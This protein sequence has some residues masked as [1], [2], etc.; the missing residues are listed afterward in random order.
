L[1]K[2]LKNSN[3][4]KIVS[5][6]PTSHIDAYSELKKNTSFEPR[7]D[8]KGNVA[9]AV[10][11]FYTM[12]PSKAGNISR[13]ADKDTL[14][15]WHTDDPVDT[16]ERIRNDRIE[17]RQGNRN[18]YID[19]PSLVA[20]AWGHGNSSGGNNLGTRDDIKR[21]KSKISVMEESLA[22]LKDELLT[23]ENTLIH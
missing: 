4:L 23:L 10:Y 12:Y 5:D 20:V 17:A 6:I 3:D 7:E 16:A 2:V 21:L 19:Y 1:A 13:I 15:K 11:Y 9:R 14:F 22:T 8:H 18:P